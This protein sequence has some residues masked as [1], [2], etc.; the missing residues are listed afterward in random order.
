YW[1]YVAK[2][3]KIRSGVTELKQRLALKKDRDGDAFQRL[4]KLLRARE[5]KLMRYIDQ[6]VLDFDDVI[7]KTSN[8]DESKPRSKSNVVS[9]A[10]TNSK[11]HHVELGTISPPIS[12]DLALNRPLPPLP[13]GV[14]QPKAAKLSPRFILGPLPLTPPEKKAA[15]SA[16]D[17]G[18]GN[19][20]LGSQGFIHSYKKTA[21]LA[22]EY[23]SDCEFSA[24]TELG[25]AKERSRGRLL[26]WAGLFGSK[27]IRPVG[28]SAAQWVG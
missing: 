11:T 18:W 16:N 9:K 24:W 7:R 15:A 20:G 1:D 21:K 19:T 27:N 5:R 17:R 23:S 22:S 26:Q 3:Q 8:A 10:T 6:H 14:E 13:P 4:S 2:A 12:P 25:D 28:N